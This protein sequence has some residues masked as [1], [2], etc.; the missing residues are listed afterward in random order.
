MAQFSVNPQ[1]FNPYKNYK[2]RVKWDG[3]HVAGFSKVSRLM[4]SNEVVEHREGGDPSS[5]RR[6][7]GRTMH[8]SITLE[9]G[10]TL[11]PEFEDWANGVWNVG[12]VLGSEVSLETLRKEIIL[13]VYN[14][15]G[16]LALAYKIHRCWVSKFQA[17][18]DLDTNANAVAIEHIKLESEGLE[19]DLSVAEASEPSL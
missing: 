8:E 6:L 10:L 7:P 4:G 5:S 1:R 12:S 13:E 15:A 11:D 18:P 19:R 14:E 2:F 9:R 3:R 17:L 16:H